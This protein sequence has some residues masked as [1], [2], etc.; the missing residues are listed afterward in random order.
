MIR[1]A[2]FLVILL[3][4]PAFSITDEEIKTRIIQQ[5]INSYPGRCAC[6]YSLMKNGRKCGAMSAYSKPGGFSPICYPSDVT[7]KMID[8]YRRNYSN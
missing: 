2:V 6:P 1:I 7:P 4:L 5:S 3:A 8:E